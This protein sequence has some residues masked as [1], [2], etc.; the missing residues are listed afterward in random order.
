[1]I[2]FTNFSQN[3]SR[4]AL[5]RS[6]ESTGAIPTTTMNIYSKSSQPVDFRRPSRQEATTWCTVVHLRPK[7]QLSSTHPL[8]YLPHPFT[9]CIFSYFRPPKLKSFIPACFTPKRTAPKIKVLLTPQ[10]SPHDLIFL[11]IY[12]VCP[13]Y[14]ITYRYT[15]YPLIK[16]VLKV[17]RNQ[18]HQAHRKPA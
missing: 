5:P 17:C 14:I 12:N 7:A 1:M 13:V 10:P 8:S 4:A 2:Q 9:A 3:F 11:H 16:L 15:C 6:F 18:R